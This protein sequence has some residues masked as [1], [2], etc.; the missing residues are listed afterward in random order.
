[1]V[2]LSI[3]SLKQGACLERFDKALSENWIKV[4]YQP[5]V[6]SATGKV[7]EEEALSRWIDPK[8]GRLLPDEFVP[9]L[10]EEKLIYRLD[11]YVLE[12][13]LEK[14]RRHRKEGLFTVPVSVNLSRSDFDS[15]DIVEEI[16]KRV[17]D[18]GVG[19]D[20]INIEVTESVVGSDFDFMKSKIERFKALGFKVWMDD[21][22]RG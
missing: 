2:E 3:K 18:S 22:G 6:R 9:V 16:R 7:C 14:I 10:E 15:C 4:Y 13:V 21:F 17:D 20:M 8:N 12:Q 11:L 1:M 5:I 19:R